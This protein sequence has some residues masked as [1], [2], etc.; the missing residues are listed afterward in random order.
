MKVPGSIRCVLLC[1]GASAVL[2]FA[3]G[4]A[5]DNVHQPRPEAKPENLAFGGD[6]LSS[7]PLFPDFGPLVN[8]DSLRIIWSNSSRTR[9]TVELDEFSLYIDVVN[10]NITIGRMQINNVAFMWDDDGNATFE[11]PNFACQAGAYYTEGSLAGTY[12]ADGDVDI[13]IDYKPGSMPFMVK[14][15]F[16]ASK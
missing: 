5:G 16:I 2:A 7:I 6:L 3:T 15:R 1:L 9:A 8:A 10:L 4:C 14:S 13:V 12:T 11:R